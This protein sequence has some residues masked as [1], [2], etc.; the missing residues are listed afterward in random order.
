MNFFSKLLQKLTPKENEPKK[1]F[2]EIYADLGLFEYFE[3]GFQ[4]TNEDFPKFIKWS[5]ID[6]INTYKKDLYAYDLVFMEIVYSEK[7]LTINEE[8]PGWFQLVLKL[9]NVFETIPKDWDI[10]ITQPAFETNYTNIY[11]KTKNPTFL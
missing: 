7:A 3:E 6:Q 2:D 4:F 1:S 5:E 11:N 10:N 9:K 8:T